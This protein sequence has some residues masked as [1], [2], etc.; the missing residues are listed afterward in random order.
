MDWQSHPFDDDPEL[1]A[2]RD[3]YAAS[4]PERIGA[5]ADVWQRLGQAGWEPE[6]A[7]QLMRRAHDL[8][9]SAA[10]YGFPSVSML[11]RQ[12]EQDLK[13]L[14]TL[15]EPPSAGVRSRLGAMVADLEQAGR[16][17]TGQ[18]APV[19]AAPVAE[20]P[21]RG[22]VLIIDDD[23]SM[24]ALL[25]ALLHRNGFTVMEGE[26]G[27]AGLDMAARHTPD[28]ILLDVS[29]PGMDGYEA[30]F[31]LQNGR[32]TYHIPIVFVTAHEDD[33]D[34]ARAFAVGAADYLVK[35]VT[36]ESLLETVR[37]CLSRNQ[38]WRALQEQAAAP[39]AIET[40][41]A[42]DFT[43]FKDFLIGQTQPGP[44]EAARLARM[45]WQDLAETTAACGIAARDL[46]TLTAEF[47]GLRFLTAID[48]GKV[49]LGAFPA[50]FCRD[51]QVVALIGDGGTTDFVTSNPFNLPLLEA[52]DR[53][54][55]GVPGTIHIADG[56][57]L[58][59]LL[60]Y[61]PRTGTGPPR[62]AASAPPRSSSW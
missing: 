35:P 42:F 31:R 57:T 5:L 11:A 33:Q 48:P 58:Q 37:R 14:H 45:T 12:V 41:M 7:T 17:L 24:R 13:Q 44:A 47:C 36:E 6:A 56:A 21:S 2:L 3:D 38:R 18:A 55:A 28:L 27:D 23:P 30:C 1:K 32:A 49:R 52:I 54:F 15:D 50:S 16:S 39:V 25:S 10:S 53:A 22:L 60:E 40:R 34:K 51:N 43:R 9:G 4:L 59:P 20:P 19:A 26:T 29:M 8:S 62:A 46:A 61:R